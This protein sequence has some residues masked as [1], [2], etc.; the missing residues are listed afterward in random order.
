MQTV[1]DLNRFCWNQLMEKLGHYLHKI[2]FWQLSERN[3][4]KWLDLKTVLIQIFQIS[5]TILAHWS[6][7][8]FIFND[9]SMKH[10]IGNWNQINIKAKVSFVSNS[11]K[12]EEMICNWNQMQIPRSNCFKKGKIKMDIE[13]K[14]KYQGHFLSNICWSPTASISKWIFHHKSWAANILRKKLFWIET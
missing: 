5:A 3:H 1:E 14:Q 8:I 7:H 6:K 11:W 9:L 4:K 2:T 13:T 10:K 12:K